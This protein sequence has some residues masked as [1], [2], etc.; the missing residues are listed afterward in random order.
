[1]KH[2]SSTSGEVNAILQ[3]LEE[4]DDVVA[5][6]SALFPMA[7]LRILSDSLSGIL[8]I[9]NGGHTI[10]SRSTASYIRYLLGISHL[11]NNGMEHVPGT[12]QL[13]DPLTKVKPI[14]WYGHAND[15]RVAY[16]RKIRLR[17]TE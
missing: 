16:V 7:T 10:K 13:A 3:A 12:L 4:A 11:P 8:Q 9:N 6:A 5:V 1:M 14:G 17:K 15:Y 2:A